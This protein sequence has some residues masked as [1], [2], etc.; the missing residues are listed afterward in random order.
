MRDA[1]TERGADGWQFLWEQKTTPWNMGEPAPPLVEFISSQH[2][3]LF[4]PTSGLSYNCL[5]P[6]CGQVR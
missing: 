2:S 4:P 6:G 5:V 1:L 3:A